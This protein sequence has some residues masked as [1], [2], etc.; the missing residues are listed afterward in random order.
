MNISPKKDLDA[1]NYGIT[2]MAIEALE[3]TKGEKVGDATKAERGIKIDSAV[4]R[5]FELPTIDSNCKPH[6]VRED[7]IREINGQ[8]KK[9][10]MN[11]YYI[12]NA[13]ERAEYKEAIDK[14]QTGKENLSK[15]YNNEGM[16][17]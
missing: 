17:K 6:K 1:K 15:D 8:I 4:D 12:N 9:I 7:G 14:E 13:S 16:E 11:G 2:C 10:N 3:N 5:N